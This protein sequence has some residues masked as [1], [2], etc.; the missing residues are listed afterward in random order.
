MLFTGT[1]HVTLDE[2][3]FK[4]CLQEFIPPP[5]LSSSLSTTDLILM[6]FPL[7]RFQSESPLCAWFVTKQFFSL[8]FV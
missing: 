4:E 3:H 5:P 6:G 2:V 8:F 7:R 1:Y